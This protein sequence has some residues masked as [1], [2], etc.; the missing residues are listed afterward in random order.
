MG[1]VEVTI[2][3]GEQDILDLIAASETCEVILNESS[4]STSQVVAAGS[5]QSNPALSA[6]PLKPSL[7]RL[8]RT[9]KTSWKPGQR[10]NMTNSSPRANVSSLS[11]KRKTEGKSDATLLP[12]RKRQ[13][14]QNDEMP[15][16][17]VQQMRWAIRDARVSMREAERACREAIAGGESDKKG[18]Q[19]CGS[20]GKR[21]QERIKGNKEEAQ[22]SSDS[23]EGISTE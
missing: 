20:R 12:V 4:P 10:W 2:A 18:A 1:S 6:T 3:E 16:S 11:R 9:A 14:Q 19:S 15:G 13:Y 21:C 22:S 23:P 8:Q 5:S 17:E 7:G